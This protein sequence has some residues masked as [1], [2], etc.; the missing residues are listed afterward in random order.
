MRARA[1]TPL[2]RCPRR[3]H[4]QPPARS[5]ARP[6]ARPPLLK[7]TT[8]CGIS[9]ERACL[10]DHLARLQE[11]GEVL[12]EPISRRPDPALTPSPRLALTL[13]PTRA[14]APSAQPNPRQAGFDPISRKPLQRIE[15]AVPNL[16]LKEAISDFLAEHP[17][18][19][20]CTL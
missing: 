2:T 10:R 3:P 12:P 17:W 6:P 11:R 15:Q 14:Q 18:A 8:P 4:T 16:A 7:V 1:A 9:Y 19:Y 5:P 13:T 20:Q